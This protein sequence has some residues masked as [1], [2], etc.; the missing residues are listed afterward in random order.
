M[1]HELATALILLLS[2]LTMS[3]TGFGFALVSVPL[4]ALFM[5]IKT[6]VALQFPY[7]LVMFGIQAWRYRSLVRWADMR[8]LLYGTAVGL[9][10][11]AFLLYYLPE[12]MLKRALAVLI[13]GAVLLTLTAW[14]RKLGQRYKDNRWWGATAGFLS[15]WFLGAYTIGGPP[16]AV[17]ILARTEDPAQAKGLMSWYFTGQFVLMIFIYGAAGMFTLDGLLASAWYSPVVVL[18]G[19]AGGWAFRR[20]GNRAFRLAVNGLLVLTAVLLW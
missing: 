8:D 11:G 15:G 13:L 5:P 9:P 18:G 7:C 2:A 6:A 12:M 3:F 20:V 10:L 14:G 16:A 1:P 17:Y 4:L 19:V